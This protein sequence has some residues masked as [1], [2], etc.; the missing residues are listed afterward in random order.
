MDYLSIENKKRRVRNLFIGGGK[1]TAADINRICLCNDA[2]KY[3]S[4]LR[5]EGYAIKDVRLD[6]GCKLYWLER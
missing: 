3:V 2:R 5:N 1:F 4:M 6:N